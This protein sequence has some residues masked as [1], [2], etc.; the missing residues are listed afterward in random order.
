MAETKNSGKAILYIAASADG[1]IAGENDDLS[2][3]SQVENEHEDYGFAEFMKS[4]DVSIMG[5]RTID[6]VLE[7]EPSFLKQNQTTYVITHRQMPSS[8]LNSSAK[9]ITY[10]GD[11]SDLV[12]ELQSQGKN[13]FIVGGSEIILQL[14]KRG[15]IDEFIIAIIPVLLGKGTL[16]FKPGFQQTVLRLLDARKFSSGL[17]MIKYA[18][19]QKADTLVDASKIG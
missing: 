17:V 6:W 2:F 11:V 3:L 10:N 16:L 1:Y 4:I 7:H 12:I 13:L 14:M 18:R 5:R 8:T 19:E 15:L 9:I